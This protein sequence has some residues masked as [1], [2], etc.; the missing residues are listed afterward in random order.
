MESKESQA[1]SVFECEFTA[2]REATKR[3]AMVF[4]ATGESKTVWVIAS[5]EHQAKMALAEHIWPMRKVPKREQWPRYME[6]Y[7]ELFDKA[8]E[9]RAKE[10]QSQGNSDE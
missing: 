6:L 1:A 9:E 7:V 8:A 4:K 5:T 2:L 3:N 10:T